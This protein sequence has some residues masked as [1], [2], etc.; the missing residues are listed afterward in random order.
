M[1]GSQGEDPDGGARR[2][3]RVGDIDVHYR[4][5]GSG[6]PIVALHGW[7]ETSY[8][9]RQVGPLLAAAGN[10]QVLAPDTRGHGQTSAPPSGYTRGELAADVVGF[11]DALGIERAPVVAHD[12]GGI[13]AFKVAVDHGDRVER[14]ALLD[15]ITTGWPC[16]VDYF[17]WFMVPGLPE[18]FFTQHAENF[19]RTI[20]GRR[21]TPPLPPPP[22]CP[23]NM[24]PELLAV[25]E[26]ARDTDVEEYVSPYRNP[27]EIAATCN[28]YRSLRFNRVID[29]SAAPHG[30]RYEP[31]SHEDMAAAWLAGK[32]GGE[33]L[34]YGVEDRHKTYGGPTLWISSS[35]VAAAAGDDDPAFANFRRHFP[36][37]TFEVVEA[38]HFLCEEAPELTTEALS[39]FLAKAP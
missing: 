11:M 15:T 26:W 1:T 32:A 27:A 22:E 3:V 18:R 36:D 16:F 7:P 33:Y 30:E 38:G 12:W 21:G 28:Y 37:L 14:L 25:R 6:R 13:I 17:Y 20:I 39:R 10:W 2:Q 29:D 19:I 4:S 5:W 8:E 31:V 35:G 9:W 34:D 23:F 24:P